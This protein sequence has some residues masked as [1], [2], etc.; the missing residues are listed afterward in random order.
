[1]DFIRQYKNILIGAGVA[2]LVFGGYYF[3]KSR[4][5]EEGPSLEVTDLFT[6]GSSL[7]GRVIGQQ[8]ISI[9]NDLKQIEIDKSA[10]GNPVFR[11]L[12]DYTI[13][14]TSETYGRPD[15]FAPLPFELEKDADKK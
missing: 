13:A 4:S 3:W 5:S 11:S 8:I 15:P 9:L 7:E 6:S 2:L 1:M 12:I 14:T 10:F